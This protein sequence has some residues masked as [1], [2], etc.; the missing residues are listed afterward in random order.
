MRSTPLPPS[1]AG[2]VLSQC[3][4]PPSPPPVQVTFSANAEYLDLVWGKVALVRSCLALDV[5]VHLSDV[6][7]VYLRPAWPS[8]NALMDE[9]GAG[10]G[11]GAGWCTS[12]T[13]T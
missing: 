12:A 8:F 9:V 1:P 11:G 10:K 2:R 3:G 13:W 5:D 7:V 4:V 6:D